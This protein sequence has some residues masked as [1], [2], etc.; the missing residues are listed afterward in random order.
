MSKFSFLATKVQDAYFFN[1]ILKNGRENFPLLPF[2]VVGGAK[3]NPM[4]K[5]FANFLMQS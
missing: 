2:L 5:T 4:L 3:A 1:T